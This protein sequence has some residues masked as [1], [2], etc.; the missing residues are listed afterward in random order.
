MRIWLEFTDKEIDLIKEGNYDYGFI[1]DRLMK[2]LKES[3]E[4]LNLK[5]V[6]C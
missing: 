6:R 2:A 5:D 3:K 1:K 4:E